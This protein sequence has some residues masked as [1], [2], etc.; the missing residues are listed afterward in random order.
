MKLLN[1]YT[2]TYFCKNSYNQ[3]FFKI[4]VFTYTLND[5]AKWIL[6]CELG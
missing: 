3:D 5:L 4:V 2:R 1:N 6:V